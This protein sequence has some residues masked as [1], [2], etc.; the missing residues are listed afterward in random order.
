M[1]VFSFA[2]I[3]G[4]T[5]SLLSAK[6]SMYIIP[7]IDLRGGQCVRLTEGREDSEKVY[8]RDPVE[9]A[10]HYEQAGAQL[11]H[12]VD[13]DGA[14]LGAQGQNLDIIRRITR[15]SDVPVEVG[16]GVRSFED[17]ETLLYTAG[18]SFVIVGTL[19]VEQP[20]IVREAVARYG[21]ALVVGI[22]ARGDRVATRG[23]KE[24]TEIGVFDLAEQ[25]V[26]MGVQRLIYTD[27]TR[28]GRLAGPNVEMTRAL[29]RA[30]G[31]RVTASGGVSS[32]QDIAQLREFEAEG[33]DSVIVGKALYE[34][35]F[36]I[37]EAIAAATGSAP[38]NQDDQEIVQD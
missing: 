15:E 32:L 6:A 37:E 35:R 38:F 29:A 24:A 23:W 22:D 18:A 28:D 12:V 14:F 31:V 19:A 1:P 27:I 5:V 17:I 33:I 25:V 26:E 2:A 20:A 9:V 16:G 11:I 13:L 30:T 3:T 4:K 10:K 34:D 36:T 7:A 8:A 21:D